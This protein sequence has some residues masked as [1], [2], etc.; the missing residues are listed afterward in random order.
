MLRFDV[1]DS[2]SKDLDSEVFKDYMK[3]K[4]SDSKWSNFAPFVMSRNYEVVADK[5]KDLTIYCDDVWVCSFPRSGTTLLQEMVWLI[6]HDF[7]Y[8]KS[9]AQIL[10]E[11][12]PEIE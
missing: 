11:R 9:K 7:N 5:V 3:V 4:H 6:L 12:F 10:D 1:T 2:F 8:E